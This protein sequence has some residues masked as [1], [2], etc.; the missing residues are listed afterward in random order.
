MRAA[1]PAGGSQPCKNNGPIHHSIPPHHGQA[2]GRQCVLGAT[3]R[4]GPAEDRPLGERLWCE[5]IARHGIG[6]VV[7]VH[8]RW[9][10]DCG[11]PRLPAWP[12]HV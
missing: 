2:C 1:G 7:G 10:M 5:P 3:Q 12:D 9:L 4:L 8:L 6:R 11:R